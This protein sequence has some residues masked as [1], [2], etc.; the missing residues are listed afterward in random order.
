VAAC[1][2]ALSDG[3]SIAGYYTLASAS[4]LLANLLASTGWC[5]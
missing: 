2:V 4:V 3:Q 1:F 5:A